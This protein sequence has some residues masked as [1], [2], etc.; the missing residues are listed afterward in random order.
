DGTLVDS[1]E[2]LLIAVNVAL[3]GHGRAE[4]DVHQLRRYVGEGIE[5]LLGQCFNGDVPEGAHDLFVQKYDEICCDKSRLL[6][7]V[8][9]T[10]AA[11][12]RA[13]VAMS[14]CTNKPTSFSEKILTALGTARFFRAI[15]GP[16][17]AGARKPDARHVLHALAPTGFAPADALFVGDM[18]IDVQAAR[19][20]GLHAAAIPTGSSDLEPL[21][22][23]E[24]DYLMERF[25]DLLE[26][27]GTGDGK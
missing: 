16:D 24:P 17:L 1:Y 8:E 26:I 21:S 19:A 22:A 5:P 4:L 14:V 7:N 27:V 10:L 13:G 11:L 18:P 23:S 20:A 9:Q 3:A 2:A 6:D 25:G 15:I 12:D